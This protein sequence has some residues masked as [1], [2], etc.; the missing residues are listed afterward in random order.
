MH[1]REEE[2]QAENRRRLFLKT[3]IELS[4]Y[5]YIKKV[6][7]KEALLR[8]GDAIADFCF[9]KNRSLYV[10]TI[11]IPSQN[12]IWLVNGRVTLSFCSLQVS[13]SNPKG[14]GAVKKHKKEKGHVY[15]LKKDKM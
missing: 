9:W 7:E 1:F 5:V 11:A 6:A 13:A 15:Y 12:E 8:R 14:K 3:A 10:R 2:K 4:V